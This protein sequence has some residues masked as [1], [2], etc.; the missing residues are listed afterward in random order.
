M[1]D[2]KN[3]TFNVISG[4]V[5]VQSVKLVTSVIRLSMWDYY[6]FQGESKIDYLVK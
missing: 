2:I 5:K 4:E 3:T 6:W 1:V